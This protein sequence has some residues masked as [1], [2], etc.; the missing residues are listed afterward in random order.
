VKKIKSV[1]INL[2][3]L[4]QERDDLVTFFVS[5]KCGVTKI[6]SVD[7]TNKNWSS[8]LRPLRGRKTNFILIIYKH[9]ST[10]LIIGEDRP[11]RF[12]DNWSDKNL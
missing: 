8:W 9:S 7:K 6:S 3:K 5:Q 2:A 4:W 12:R 11:G 1:N 10:N